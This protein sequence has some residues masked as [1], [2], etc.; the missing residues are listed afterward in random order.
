MEKELNMIFFLNPRC[1]RSLTL[2]DLLNNADPTESHKGVPSVIKNACLLQLMTAT[3]MIENILVGLSAA[4]KSASD[5]HERNTVRFQNSKKDCHDVGVLDIT[6]KKGVAVV[7]TVPISFN[8]VVGNMEAKQALYE[9]VI[10]PLTISNLTKVKVFSG[11]KYCLC[12]LLLDLIL[13]YS[14]S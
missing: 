11:R 3:T 9:N 2:L 12:R 5:Y 1:V 13:I 6:G 10:L 4:D 14:P 7:K 8:E